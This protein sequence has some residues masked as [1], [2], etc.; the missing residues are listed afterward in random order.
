[1]EVSDKGEI[2]VIVAKSWLEDHLHPHTRISKTKENIGTAFND[3]FV[4]KDSKRQHS[5]KICISLGFA[6]KTLCMFLV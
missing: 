4:S 2:L 1:M 3:T 6:K 5:E